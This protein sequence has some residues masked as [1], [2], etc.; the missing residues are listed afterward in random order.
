ADVRRASRDFA[1]RLEQPG[2]PQPLHL[3][4][5]VPKPGHHGRDPLRKLLARRLELLT[6]L[7]DQRALPGQEAE[8]VDA[9]QRLDPAHTR[10]DGRLAEHLDQAELAGPGHVRAAAQLAG[11]LADLDHAD[12][13]AVLLAEQRQRAHLAGLLLGGVERAHVQVVD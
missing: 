3:A 13:I 10:P 2:R 8:R 5:G 6:E 7:A 12:L 9:Y 11:I 4:L 1:G